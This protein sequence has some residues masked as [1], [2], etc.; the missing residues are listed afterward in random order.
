MT[1]IVGPKALLHTEIAEAIYM[2]DEDTLVLEF[3]D[4]T[5]PMHPRARRFTRR[6]YT[7]TPLHPHTLA[8]TRVQGCKQT[9][10]QAFTSVFHT[11]TP[12]LK[13][14]RARAREDIIEKIPPHPP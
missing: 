6:D 5:T 3:P 2:D 12:C 10:Y 1:L 9:V 4:C 13:N 8:S 14:S 11:L 7:L